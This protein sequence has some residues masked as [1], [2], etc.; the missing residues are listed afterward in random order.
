MSFNDIGL[1]RARSG[2]RVGLLRRSARGVGVILAWWWECRSRARQRRDLA[3]LS[4]WGLRDI[5]LSRADVEGE[6]GKWPWRP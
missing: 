5:G 4:D 1:G 2:R 3:A 6:S